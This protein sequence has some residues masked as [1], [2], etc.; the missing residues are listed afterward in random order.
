MKIF[1]LISQGHWK[2]WGNCLLT[3]Y[4]F[5]EIYDKMNYSVIF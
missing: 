2:S 3:V 5:G 1:Y 4:L